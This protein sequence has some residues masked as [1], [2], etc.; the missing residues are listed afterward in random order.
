MER[1]G[2]EGYWDDELSDKLKG[3][4]WKDDKELHDLKMVK[5]GGGILSW[6]GMR[7][8]RKKTKKQ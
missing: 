7:K 1:E 3:K 4:E 8:K 6:E 5:E 2:D